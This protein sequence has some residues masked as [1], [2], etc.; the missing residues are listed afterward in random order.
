MQEAKVGQL[1]DYHPRILDEDKPVKGAMVKMFEP[2]GEIF[3]QPMIS[4]DEVD[5]WI[6]AR[7]CQPHSNEEA[8][9]G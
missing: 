7:D 2:A 6:P 5:H 8:D 9:R 1:I 3:N 4:V